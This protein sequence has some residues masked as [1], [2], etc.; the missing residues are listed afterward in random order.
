MYEED[1]VGLKTLYE[2]DRM[3][4]YSGPGNHMHLE[5]YM[6]DQYLAPLLLDQTP[7]PS[8]Y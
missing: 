4:F 3:F 2:S 6:I 5:Q 1:W 7:M 8:Q